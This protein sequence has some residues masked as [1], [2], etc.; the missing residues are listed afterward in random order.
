MPDTADL[1]P[2][3]E[4]EPKLDIAPLIDCSFLLLIYFL[5]SA[6]LEKEEADLGLILPGITEVAG[7]AVAVE[8]MRIR[9]DPGG[10]IL[11]NDE[12]VEQATNQRRLP[13]LHERLKRYRASADLANSEPMVLIDCCNEVEQQR[14][15]DVLNA[16]AKVGIR[17]V[18]L[19]R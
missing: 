10:G 5:V 13:A 19:T 14:F 4:Y 11:V 8:P 3:H 2:L 6:T 16:C 17:H 1:G 18:S 9:V 15:I 12:L 7:P